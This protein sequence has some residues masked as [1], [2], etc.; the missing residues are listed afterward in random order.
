MTLGK[1]AREIV[2][3]GR[4]TYN[5]GFNGCDETQLD[6]CDLSELL[7]LWIGFCAENGFHTNSVD[8]VEKI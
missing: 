6:A 2:F 7:E 8:Y 3:V 1:A 5:I 4:G